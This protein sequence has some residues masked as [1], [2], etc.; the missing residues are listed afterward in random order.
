M[1][2][3]FRGVPQPEKSKDGRLPSPA[4]T[5]PISNQGRRRYGDSESD[6]DSRQQ[7]NEERSDTRRSHTKPPPDLVLQSREE[8]GSVRAH[9]SAIV[10]DGS[11]ELGI[12]FARLFQARGS[13]DRPCLTGSIHTLGAQQSWLRI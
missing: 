10:L 1:F 5:G 3:S 13:G 9:Q 12:M 8:E 2:P 11:F 7:G 4:D 6:A